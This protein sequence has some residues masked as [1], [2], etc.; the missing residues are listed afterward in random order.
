MYLGHLEY[1][2]WHP[3]YPPR[4]IDGVL[5]LLELPVRIC[6]ASHI[7]TY[8]RN[9]CLSKRRIII[10]PSLTA[11]IGFPFALVYMYVHGMRYLISRST[12]GSMSATGIIMNFGRLRDIL[13]N[14]F[15][16]QSP[17]LH[18]RNF[19][20]SFFEDLAIIVSSCCGCCCCCC[21][22]IVITYS[23]H[24]ND[25]ALEDTRVTGKYLPLWYSH[26]VHRSSSLPVDTV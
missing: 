7:T 20:Q 12:W 9:L 11:F 13:W 26:E 16:S 10:E 6:N 14:V 25:L 4:R 2:C 15:S 8:T 23:R 19:L 18:T 21:C 22:F 3:L 24:W 1:I 5:G 17:Q